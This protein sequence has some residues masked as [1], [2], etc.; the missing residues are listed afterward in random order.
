MKISKSIL[1]SAC[2]LSLGLL[3]SCGEKFLAEAP[4]DQ[5]TDANFYQTESDAVQAVTAAYSELAKGGQYNA[6][7]WAMDI[8]ADI[9]VT[10]GDDGNDG[11]EYKQLEAFS[12]PPTNRVT[13]LLWGGCF[14][15]IQRANLVLQKVPGITNISTSVSGAAWARPSFCAPNTT[16][17]WCGPTA[18]CLCSRLRP[19]ARRP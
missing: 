16:S 5:I 9:S 10:G 13:N 3:G 11:I 2:L 8:M 18:T 17:T 12:I 15:G 6:A 7:L 14:V 4:S 19:P 1:R